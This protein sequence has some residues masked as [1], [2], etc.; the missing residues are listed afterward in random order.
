MNQK[1][2]NTISV[3]LG[4]LKQPWLEWCARQ[5]TKPSDALRQILAKVLGDSSMLS[6]PPSMDTYRPEKPRARLE[7]RFTPSEHVKLKAEARQHGFAPTKWIVALVRAQLTGQP[8]FGQIELEH[9]AH[10]NRQLL[11]IGRNLNQI[12]K[13]LNCAPHEQGAV[14]V[15]LITALQVIIR[16]HTETVSNIMRANVERWSI[17]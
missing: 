8:H 7:V 2:P 4:N 3:D 11:A 12:A 16:A 13:A 9:L 14:R 5:G 15:E 17:R 10:S 6:A 1:R